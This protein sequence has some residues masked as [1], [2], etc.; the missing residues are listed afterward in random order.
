MLGYAKEGQT[1][2]KQ[3]FAVKDHE[4]AHILVFPFSIIAIASVN[5]FI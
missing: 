4:Q 3:G 1:E 5:I 2:E